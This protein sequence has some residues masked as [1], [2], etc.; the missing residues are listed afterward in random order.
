M[1]LNQLRY[2][3]AIADN[4]LNITVAARALHTSQPAVS[5]QIRHLEDELGFA[6]FVREGRALVRT[7][8]A[9]EQVIDRARRLVRDAQGI[10]GLAADLRKEQAGSLSI[11]TTHTQARYVLPPVLRQFR[12]RFPGVRL[13]LYQGTSEHIAELVRLNRVDLAI[14]T[15]ASP[16]FDDLIRLPVY[17][18]RRVLVVPDDHPLAGSAAPSVQELARY[19]L[20]T[21]S[22]SFTGPSS[23]LEAFADEGVTPNIALTAWD[24]DVI[25]T[26]VREGFGVG[27]VADIAIDG[28]EDA[29][30]RVRDLS[31]LFAPHTTW[32]GFPRGA[33]LRRYM[34]DFIALLAPHLSRRQV[35]ALEG[36]ESQRQ[37]DEALADFPVPFR[38]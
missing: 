18:W 13:H 3:V 25:K 17:Q 35:Q 29:D 23:V 33:L 22:F 7:T 6:M 26:Y 11:A 24:S 1:K 9:G 30:L 10:R 34:Y 36:A 14:A 8:P 12:E 27:I 21:Y 16:L 38:R 37:V 19:P 15:G 20:I 4:D 32:I 31:H 2:L 28:Y 5:K